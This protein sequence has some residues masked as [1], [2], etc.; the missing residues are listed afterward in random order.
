VAPKT[1]TA[2]T[3]LARWP[4]KLCFLWSVDLGESDA[5]LLTRNQQDSCIAIGDPY[6]DAWQA[7]SEGGIAGYAPNK[8]DYGDGSSEEKFFVVLCIYRYAG[9]W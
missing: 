3:C 7:F 9:C 2:R 8:K 1:F 6:D 4:Y 5:E